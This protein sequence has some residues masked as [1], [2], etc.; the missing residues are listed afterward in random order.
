MHL[1]ATNRNLSY[2]LLIVSC[3][4][5]GTFWGAKSRRQ[6]SEF[7]GQTEPANFQT[8]LLVHA[9]RNV[10]FTVVK[11]SAKFTKVNPFPGKTGSFMSSF[12][13]FIVSRSSEELIKIEFPSSKW[14]MANPRARPVYLYLFLRVA[15]WTIFEAFSYMKPKRNRKQHNVT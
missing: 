3:L 15:F 8:F 6:A 4:L 1:L 9:S 5:F 7:G 12:R 14:R 11:N 10:M 2:S 13:Y